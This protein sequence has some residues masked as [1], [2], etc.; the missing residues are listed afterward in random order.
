MDFGQ[1]KKQSHELWDCFLLFFQKLGLGFQ[2]FAEHCS[3]ITVHWSPDTALPSRA[4]AR[5][6]TSSTVTLRC[7]VCLTSRACARVATSSPVNQAKICRSDF[8]RVRA[9]CTSVFSSRF[10]VFGSGLILPFTVRRTPIAEHRLPHAAQVPASLTAARL[11]AGL[12]KSPQA[13]RFG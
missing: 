12:T 9:Y 2:P 6:A 8:S 5:V 1:K 7:R 4:C 11:F 13:Y 3:P 10:T